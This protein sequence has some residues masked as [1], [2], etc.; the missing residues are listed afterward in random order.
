M[1]LS[2]VETCCISLFIVLLTWSRGNP[3]EEYTVSAPVSSLTRI[4]YAQGSLYEL[5][6]PRP[7]MTDSPDPS[8]AALPVTLNCRAA[9]HVTAADRSPESRVGGAI[10]TRQRLLQLRESTVGGADG[11]LLARLKQLGI[12]KTA[13]HR[14]VRGGRKSCRPI[15]VRISPRSSAGHT[16]SDSGDRLG[17]VPRCLVRPPRLSIRQTIRQTSSAAQTGSTAAPVT[18]SPTS[19]SSITIELLNVQSLLPKLP[20]ITAE[21]Q[22]RDPDVLCYTE[23]NLKSGTPNRL[24]SLPGYQV[25]RQDRTLGRKKAGG[26]VAIYIRDSFQASRVAAP[27]PSGQSYTESIWLSVKLTKRRA[28]SIGCIYRPPSTSATQVNADF[29][30]IEE[31]L[32]AVIA[33]H[34]AQRIALTGDLNSDAQTNPTAHRR[35][36]E[37]G[38]RFGLCNVVHQATFLR[39]NVRSILDVVLLSREMCD[40]PPPPVPLVETCHFVAHHRRVAI[41]LPIPRVRAKPAYRTG[42]NWRDFDDQAFLNDVRHTDWHSIVRVGASC[43]QQWDAFSE[44]MTRLLDKHAPV[45]RYKV[46]NPSPPPVSQETLDL[47]CQRREALRDADTEAYQLLNSQ[48]KRAIRRDMR[49]DITR[50][51]QSAPASRLFRQLEPVIAPRRGPPVPPVGLSATDL[52]EYFCSIG[53]TTRDTVKAEFERSGRRP[54]DVRLPR[55]HTE[56]LNIIPVT[57]NQLLNVILSLPSKDS[58]ASGDVPIKI[59]KLCFSHI[60]HFLL[61]IINNSIVSETVPASWKCAIVIPLHKKGDPSQASNFRPITNVPAICKIVEKLVHQ[62]ITAYLDHYSLFSPDQHGFMTRHSTTTALLSITDQILQGMDRSEI[63]LLTLI[64]L[65]RCFDVVDHA[66]LLTSLEQ[67]QIATGWIK[68]YL[69]G[70]TQRVRVGDVLSE[71]RII[72]IG[73]FQGSCLGPLLFNIVSNNISCYIPSSISGFRTFSVRYADDTQVAITGPRSRL[74]EMKLALESLLDELSTWFSQHGMMVNASKTELLVCGD[75]RQLAQITDPPQV[76]FMGQTLTPTNAAKNLGVVMDSELS[77]EPHINSTIKRCFGILIGLMHIRHII[78]SNVL[79]K[80]ID[81]L[82]FSHLRYAASVYGSASRS[83]IVKL[84]KVINFSAKVVS[85]RRKYDHVSDVISD[86]SWL[87][88]QDIVKYFDL[89]LIHGIISYGKPDVLRSWIRHNHEHV[90]RNT[91]QSYHLTLPSVKNNHGKR[92]FMYR[93]AELYNRLAIGNGHCGLP[94]TRFKA[95]MREVLCE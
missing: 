67:L 55:V 50:R 12:S 33:A 77:W 80:I 59:L 38:E 29:D 45:R 64:D 47:M 6:V 83:Q 13:K 3:I 65:S 54:L 20:D 81:A 26:G 10:Y 94:M 27:A 62:Q 21:L 60:G 61:R 40:V 15:P 84:Q 9:G 52:N 86:L 32:Q 30:D 5:A 89:S 8:A 14:G 58:C 70:H 28:T 35:L 95:K 23:T 66:T 90:T 76:D 39:G 41:Q 73:T 87:R 36:R 48:T 53:R 85:G 4:V 92:R 82:V 11:D 78:P 43:E 44:A 24:I 19:T 16:P 57:Y 63:T 72:D 49:D 74:P 46:H 18:T 51:V 79:P 91:R 75:R 17:G 7:T 25:F 68:S 1:W 69:T 56:A 37:L 42:R 22:H 93:A 34:P 71:P 31:Q 2:L 88:A